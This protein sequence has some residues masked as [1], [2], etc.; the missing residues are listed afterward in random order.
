MHMNIHY[1]VSGVGQEDVA[2]VLHQTPTNGSPQFEPHPVTIIP[3][4][5]QHHVTYFPSNTKIDPSEDI[6][7][8]TTLAINKKLYRVIEFLQV[9]EPQL[10]GLTPVMSLPKPAVYADIQGL[11]RRIPDG[12][13]RMMA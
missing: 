3:S 2:I 10:T 1:E 5:M 11:D 4:E 9:I 12:T 6:K 13:L 8:L 7:R